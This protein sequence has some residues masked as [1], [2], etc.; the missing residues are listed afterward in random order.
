MQDLSIVLYEKRPQLQTDGGPD[1][2]L[3]VR[4]ARRQQG[5]E[6]REASRVTYR[7][8]AC[9]YRVVSCDV[10]WRDVTF[11]MGLHGVMWHD[12]MRRHMT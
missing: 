3:H 4:E 10:T 11:D 7:V 12:T 6:H 9:R 2:E 8:A 5:H 1:H